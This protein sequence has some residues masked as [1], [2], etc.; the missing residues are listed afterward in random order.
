MA[1]AMTSVLGISAASASADTAY[2]DAAAGTTQIE[3]A[4]EGDQTFTIGNREVACEEF[5]GSADYGEPATALTA[6]G[7]AFAGCQTTMFGIS[8]PT[9][10]N[11]SEGCQFTVTAG[12]Y[13]SEGSGSSAGSAQICQLVIKVYQPGEPAT[14]QCEITLP[15]QSL[16]GFAY[17][18]EPGGEEF[19]GSI[20]VEVEAGAEAT[21]KDLNRLGC[22]S[23]ET[24]TATYAGSFSLKG[25]DK[26]G[27]QRRTTVTHHGLFEA[28]ET[29]T[30]PPAALGG[31]A[32]T[33]H[34]FGYPLLGYTYCNN[35]ALSNGELEGSSESITLTPSYSGCSFHGYETTIE[36]HGCRY[37]F[38]AGY[39][40]EGS[41]T[42][43]SCSGKGITFTAVH[44]CTVTIPP[45]TIAPVSFETIGSGSE[46]EIEISVNGSGYEY[47]W[48]GSGLTCSA[49]GGEGSSSV[50]YSGTWD[51]SAKDEMEN[52]VGAWIN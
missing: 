51:V 18:N 13:E 10:V 50:L 48:A 35:S 32:T 47:T 1:L 28:E 7:I 20:G 38:D 36:T 52:Q 12:T 8:F 34:S 19:P 45:Q 5:E 4:A 46:R 30:T 39:E 11:P 29:E 24:V 40:G 31:L 9:T 25:E 33:T 43:G 41:M 14:Q 6:T 42:I 26:N 37:T 3:A 23:D 49:G 27:E 2:F 15:G 22:N 21:V 17:A 16:S 44:N